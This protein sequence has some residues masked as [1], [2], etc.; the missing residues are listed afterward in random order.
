MPSFDY[1]AQC[2]PKGYDCGAGAILADLDC[3]GLYEVWLICPDGT[4][5]VDFDGDGCEEACDCCPQ[6]PGPDAC[7]IPVQ[8]TPVK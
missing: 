4:H 1:T 8:A 6:L 2:D 7:P 3:D 5:A